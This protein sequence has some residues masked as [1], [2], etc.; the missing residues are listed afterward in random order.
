MAGICSH[1]AIINNI[2]GLY[3]LRDACEGHGKYFT[4]EL[5]G[6]YLPRRVFVVQDASAFC[7]LLA[8]AGTVVSDNSLSSTRAT[9]AG[10]FSQ[11][12][13]VKLI[14]LREHQ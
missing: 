8:Q 10:G 9:H 2:A 4:R 5:P 12:E 3:P 7:K 11:E 6:N 1:P 13:L 14:K